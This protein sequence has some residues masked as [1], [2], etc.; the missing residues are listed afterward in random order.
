MAPAEVDQSVSLVPGFVWS[1]DKFSLIV[2][3]TER[4]KKKTPDKKELSEILIKPFQ[5]DFFLLLYSFIY[6]SI[7]CIYLFQ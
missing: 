6:R 2:S 4:R 5:L 1:V 7:Y 3:G